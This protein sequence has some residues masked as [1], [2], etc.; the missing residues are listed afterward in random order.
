MY[1]IIFL[2]NLQLSNDDSCID[3]N[4]LCFFWALERECIK[5]PE[6]ML[7]NCKRSCEICVDPTFIQSIFN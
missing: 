1:N 4:K 5:N 7:I 3:T 6:W 2:V